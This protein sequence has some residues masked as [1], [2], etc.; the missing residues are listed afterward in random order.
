V[1]VPGTRRPELFAAAASV[2]LKLPPYEGS[3][4]KAAG[5]PAGSVTL[6]TMIRPRFVF[7]N[8][9]VTVSPAARLIVAVRVARLTLELFD[10][11]TQAMPVRSQPARPSSS[12]V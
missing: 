1:Y 9:Q 2:R 7:V 3:N 5:S 8:V 10:G 11:S 4:S 6:S 12:T